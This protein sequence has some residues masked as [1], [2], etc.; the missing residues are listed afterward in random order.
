M[1]VTRDM[2]SPFQQQFPKTLEHEK[3]VPNLHGKLKYILHYRNLKLY[4]Q[5]GLRVVKTHR[6]IRFKH[7]PWLRGYIDMNIQLRREATVRGD[8]ADKDLYKLL[9]HRHAEATDTQSLI[10]LDANSLYA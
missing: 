6:C 4:T 10:Y 7:T 1:R 9:S 3:L 2:L 5:L 8:K